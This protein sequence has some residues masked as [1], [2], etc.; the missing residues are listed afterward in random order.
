MKTAKLPFYILVGFN[1]LTW[2]IYLSNPYL[3]YVS[4]THT[5]TILYVLINIVALYLGLKS[6]ERNSDRYGLNKYTTS[7]SFYNQYMNYYF[8][9]Y[10][11]TFT[12]KYS[13]ELRCPALDLPA[14]VNRILVGL[15]NADVGYQ[16]TLQ[17]VQSFSWSLYTIIS[18]VDCGFFIVGMLCWRHM[19]K[20]QKLLFLLL[21]VF[22]LFKWFGAG[23]SFGIMQLC[24]TF[25]LVYIVN[26]SREELSK[27][28]ILRT[29]LVVL[30]ILINQI[31]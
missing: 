12:L 3:N 1:L 22:E 7:N 16:L 30:I 6:G 4:E 10:I 24:T 28:Q 25:V 21:V 5:I 27:R 19:S 20:R 2:I 17:G 8:V 13:Y 9:L 15:A 31:I 14:L 11:L 26:I 18:I 29:G 23:T